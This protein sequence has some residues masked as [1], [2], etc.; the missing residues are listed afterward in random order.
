MIPA[1]PDLAALADAV[2]TPF[3]CYNA[4]TLRARV[5]RVRDAF[6][7]AD[8]FYSLKANPNL[9]VVRTLCEAGAKAEICSL[10]ELEIAL[11]AGVAAENIIFVGPAKG[12]PELTRAVRVGIRA[13]VAES[14]SEL[15][16]LDEIAASHGAC[17]AVALRINPAFH[18]SGA[19]LAM[20]GRA[21]QFGIDSEILD[22]A[23]DSL[24]RLSHLRLHGLH[25][26]MG[27]RILDHTAIAENTRRILEL[28]DAVARQTGKA[29]DFVDVGGGFG[30]PYFEKEQELDLDAL[31]RDLAPELAARQRQQP[32]TRIAFELGR[33]LTAPAGVFVTRVRAVKETKGKRFAICDGGSNCNSAAAGLGSAF[34]KNLPITAVGKAKPNGATTLW[35][36]TGP[37]CTPTDIIGQDVALPELLPGDL[38]VIDQSGAYGPSASPVHF[39]G[40][41]H[42]AEIMVDGAKTL[43]VRQAD[44]IEHSL[45]MQTPQPLDGARIRAKDLTHEP[46]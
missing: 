9:S 4:E 24:A 39:L 33:Y 28:A 3:Y 46:A 29:L 41:G 8:L 36:L 37:L 25:V 23:L 32:Q 6:P 12:I 31:A 1:P 22:A 27:T 13:V 7:H 35:I 20:S 19:R 5:R 44:S 40:F 2:G 10:G 26:Y 38:I 15:H 11:A 43:I 18:T 17:Q 21:T 42:P 16:L 45:K 14:L 34:R 30:V